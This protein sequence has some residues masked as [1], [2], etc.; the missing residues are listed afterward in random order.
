MFLKCK[1]LNSICFNHELID[2]LFIRIIL[3]VCAVIVSNNENGKE[4][5]MLTIHNACNI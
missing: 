2:N 3:A 1:R 5:H 4:K